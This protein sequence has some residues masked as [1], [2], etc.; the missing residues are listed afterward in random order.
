MICN[1][2]WNLDFLKFSHNIGAGYEDDFLYVGGIYLNDHSN[3]GINISGDG[4]GYIHE[5][6]LILINW[7]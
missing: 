4:S 2:N 3:H 7:I 1:D 5:R 6:T